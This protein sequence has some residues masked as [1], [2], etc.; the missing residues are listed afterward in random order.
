MYRVFFTKFWK[1]SDP[2]KVRGLVWK[3]ANNRLQTLNNLRKRNT[4]PIGA[5]LKCVFCRATPET[6][7]HLMFHYN[8]QLR[9]G[10]V[11]ISG[12]VR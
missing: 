12:V 6:A 1:I 9:F 3:L 8:L 4:W 2:S 5:Y 7:S 11:V 10:V